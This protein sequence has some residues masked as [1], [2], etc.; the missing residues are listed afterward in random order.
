[1]Q[2]FLALS[3]SRRISE[4]RS[5]KICTNCLRSTTHTASKC[6]SGNCKTCKGKHSTLLHATTSTD[7]SDRD[8]ENREEPAPAASPTALVMHTSDLPDNG[9][10]W[11][12]Y[13]IH[14]NRPVEINY[15]H[16]LRLITSVNDV[17][18]DKQVSNFYRDIVSPS[19][20][21]SS[22]LTRQKP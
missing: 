13:H 21:R 20:T 2:D 3:A 12:N 1:M 5:R 18:Y 9:Y 14:A 10:K 4:I 16:G 22:W 17:L 19:S 11:C 7:L 15:H 8:K 6:P